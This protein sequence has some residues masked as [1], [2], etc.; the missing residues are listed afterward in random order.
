MPSQHEQ[1]GNTVHLFIGKGRSPCT[2][3]FMPF[4]LANNSIVIIRGLICLFILSRFPF[5]AIM[6]KLFCAQ[7]R[8]HL[9]LRHNYLSSRSG[10]VLTALAY[11]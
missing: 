3:T 2:I 7:L 6:S 9:D 10:F 4:T 5:S 8:D 11:S 1:Y